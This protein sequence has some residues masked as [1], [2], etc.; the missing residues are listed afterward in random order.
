[1]HPH[2]DAEEL[3]LP[4]D[5]ASYVAI[6][7]PYQWHR[8]ARE[9]APLPG[10]RQVSRTD[11]LA[12]SARGNETRGTRDE[13]ALR[14]A[15]RLVEENE[16]RTDQL[17]ADH[18]AFAKRFIAQRELIVSTNHGVRA[19]LERALRNRTLPASARSNEPAEV[20]ARAP[21][22]IESVGPDARASMSEPSDQFSSQRAEPSGFIN[23][24]IEVPSPQS[25][26]AELD[27][28]FKDQ[29]R[30]LEQARLLLKQPKSYFNTKAANESAE[31]FQQRLLTAA[32]LRLQSE[33]AAVR[34]VPQTMVPDVRQGAPGLRP[35]ML[36][37]EIRMGSARPAMPVIPPAQTPQRTTVAFTP[38]PAT[39]PIPAVATRVR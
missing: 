18:D 27:R 13:R 10:L 33:Q 11:S 21:A 3:N 31:A 7:R 4:E 9:T 16:R 35:L 37:P 36:N 5:D 17:T 2:L 22:P 32:R 23:P 26:D 1:M 38:L 24:Q 19:T 15:L 25:E 6:R 39:A 14:D 28:Q 29:I 30:A 8:R 12:G 20:E 34:V